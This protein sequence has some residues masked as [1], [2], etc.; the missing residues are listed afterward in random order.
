MDAF[1]ADSTGFQRIHRINPSFSISWSP[2]KKQHWYL[3]APPPP[4]KPYFATQHR[5][6]IS[7]KTLGSL[8]SALQFSWTQGPKWMSPLQPIYIYIYIY[9]TSSTRTYG[10][11]FVR[12]HLLSSYLQGSA[13]RDGHF[14]GQGTPFL[15]HMWL[16]FTPPGRS[17][18]PG[19]WCPCGWRVPLARE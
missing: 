9:E 5:H 16:P 18:D 4:P 12:V 15:R 11:V 17:R 6:K 14:G 8:G 3:E 19:R 10:R 7:P 13:K 2:S 1:S